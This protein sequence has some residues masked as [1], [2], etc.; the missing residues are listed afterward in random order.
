MWMT[1]LDRA[2]ELADAEHARLTLAKT[3]GLGRVGMCL[4]S[5]TVLTCAPPVS[6]E[7]LQ[8]EASQRLA[9]AAESVSD[10]IPLS[11]VV[12]SSDTP[13][14]LER[15]VERSGH[16]LIVVSESDLAHNR[17]LRRAVCK[18]GIAALMVTSEPMAQSRL[19][20]H[21][22]FRPRPAPHT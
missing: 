10:W 13:R 5:F 4:C 3:S 19:P 15:L 20:V 22:A 12:L 1:V 11:T 17:G 16:D 18:L 21:R 14:A 7:Q 9:Q 8:A 6:K 2:V